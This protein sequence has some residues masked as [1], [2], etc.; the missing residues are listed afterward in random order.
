M[1]QEVDKLSRGVFDE[2]ANRAVDSRMQLAASERAA[3]NAQ[4]R[5][6]S[7][8]KARLSRIPVSGLETWLRKEVQRVGRRASPGTPQSP[9]S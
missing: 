5:I 9:F 4:Y 8:L 6:P 3:M 2:R 1:Q 7:A